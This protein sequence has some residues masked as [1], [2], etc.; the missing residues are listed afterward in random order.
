MHDFFILFI[1]SQ[2]EPWASAKQRLGFLKIFHPS[3]DTDACYTDMCGGQQFSGSGVP[4]RLQKYLKT[5]LKI[6]EKSF[7]I[8]LFKGPNNTNFI[9]KLPKLVPMCILHF[10]AISHILQLF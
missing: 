9:Q 10:I 2:N 8:L 4:E 1:E 3:G 7:N 5:F 6:W